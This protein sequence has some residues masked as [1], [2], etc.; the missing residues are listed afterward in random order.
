MPASNPASDRHISAERQ[1]PDRNGSVHNGHDAP[2]RLEPSQ[3]RRISI[4]LQEAILQLFPAGDDATQVAQPSGD[5]TA[6]NRTGTS[7]VPSPNLNGS[8]L[9][10]SVQVHPYV[11]AFATATSD[12][13]PRWKRVLDLSLVF[14]TMW[15]WLPVMLVITCLIKIVS[16]GPAFYRQR[17]V[18]FQGHTF[19][20]FKFRSMKVN[21]ETQS[22][23]DYV[24]HLMQSESPL[25]KLDAIDPR[26]IP[27]GRFL[28]ATG[29]D[30]LPQLF[31]VI[32]GEMSLV[33]PRP[34]IDR[35]FE[36]YLPWQKARVNAPPGLTGFWQVNGKNKTTFNQ[37]MQMDLHYAREMSLWLDLSILGRTL[38]AIFEQTFASFVGKTSSLKVPQLVSVDS[39]ASCGGSSKP[40]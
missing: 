30:E 29:L 7:G 18:G 37:M 9:N 26:L 34:C 3:S 12:H 2:L 14:L 20:I 32:R 5:L 13:F 38:P 19:M 17:R 24:N 27:F 33:G 4:F 23:E 1:I 21:A 22:H 31:N 35:E 28:R 36:H 39:P 25:T 10:G 11:E 15:L 40:L 6:E 8:G 16:P